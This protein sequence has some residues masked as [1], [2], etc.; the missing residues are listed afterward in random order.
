MRITLPGR[1]VDL[2]LVIASV[3]AIGGAVYFKASTIVFETTTVGRM[4]ISFH[5][6]RTRM[7]LEDETRTLRA[8]TV[9]SETT[10]KRITSIAWAE[11]DIS[12]LI[13]VLLFVYCCCCCCSCCWLLAVVCMFVL[14][15]LLPG[16]GVICSTGTVSK[17][18]SSF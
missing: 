4:L 11:V 17:F 1:Q 13:C 12:R 5:V 8:N 9:K 7:R 6:Q 14:L 2:T 16:W 15:F 18:L 3:S 10:L